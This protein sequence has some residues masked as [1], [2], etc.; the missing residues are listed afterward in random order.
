MGFLFGKSKEEMIENNKEVYRKFLF[1]FGQNPTNDYLKQLTIEAGQNYYALLQKGKKL[2]A[3][4]EEAIKK[5]LEKAIAD[6]DQSKNFP[7][8]EN[9]LR[10][11]Y[12]DFMKRENH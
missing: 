10:K 7:T 2:T 11:I 1:N 12:E 8:E 3:E 9:E 5:D 4:D 6:A